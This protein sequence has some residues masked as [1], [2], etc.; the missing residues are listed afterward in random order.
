LPRETKREFS[1]SMGGVYVCLYVAAHARTH[2]RT[3]AH[4]HTH[5]HTHA[6]RNKHTRQ[7]SNTQA[8]ARVPVCMCACARARMRACVACVCAC[9]CLC[10][11]VLV[12]V[13]VRVCACVRLRVCV[14]RGRGGG[15][16]KLLSDAELFARRKSAREKPSGECEIVWQ[17]VC[18]R[19]RALW[20]LPARRAACR[21]ELQRLHVPR[22]PARSQPGG[23]HPSH[24]QAAKRFTCLGNFFA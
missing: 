7:H 17:A 11:C 14:C 18:L 19:M 2:A 4:T 16:G 6:A 21:L 1:R 5:T 23:K 24:R 3:H 12:G 20:R 15:G 8:L 9:G 13:R 10:V 22:H